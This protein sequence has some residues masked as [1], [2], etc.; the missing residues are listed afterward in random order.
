MNSYIV[1]VQL[2]ATTAG[3]YATSAIYEALHESLRYAGGERTIQGDDTSVGLQELPHGEYFVRTILSLV[4][5]RDLLCELVD[6]LW[7]VAEVFVTEASA[8][9][10][11]LP[12]AA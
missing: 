11:R 3:E 5:L 6:D 1:R 8:A 4:P 7:P 9:A 2:N 12:R 10:W